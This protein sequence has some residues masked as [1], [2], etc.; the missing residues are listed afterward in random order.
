MIAD[1]FD[2]PW[3]LLLDDDEAEAEIH[4]LLGVL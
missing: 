2:D 1:R 4:G 3:P